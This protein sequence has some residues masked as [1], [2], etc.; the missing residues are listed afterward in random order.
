MNHFAWYGLAAVTLT[1]IAAYLDAPTWTTITATVLILIS[2]GLS[3]A[4]SIIR[5]KA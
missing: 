5:R 3:A 1:I 4:A 2:L